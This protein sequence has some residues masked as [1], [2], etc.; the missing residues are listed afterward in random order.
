M[1]SMKLTCFFLTGASRRRASSH[2]SCEPLEETDQVTLGWPA[3]FGRATP[4]RSASSSSESVRGF[5]GLSTPC[6]DDPTSSTTPSK[7]CGSRCGRGF[8]IRVPLE[9]P[10][11]WLY[12][13]ARNAAIDQLRH[14]SR[15][16]R[17]L[18]GFRRRARE[19]KQFDAPA[20]AGATRDDEHR[21]VL[22]AIEALPPIY[23][24]VFVLRHIQ[25]WTYP[26]IADVTGIAPGT[27]ET[28][29]VR[30]RRLL[31]R[32]LRRSGE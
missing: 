16:R 20:D 31:R 3:S 29:L 17:L 22:R 25:D 4:N 1:G 10:R 26:E 11:S 14:R 15:R 32:A 30:A 19:R 9:R 28:R 13:L 6:S 5:A 27:V 2:Q 7:R 8:P 12:R 23:R 24:E 18:D 21:R